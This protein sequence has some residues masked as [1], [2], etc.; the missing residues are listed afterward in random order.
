MKLLKLAFAGWILAC[1][2]TV[3]I[4]NI[5]S[6]NGY[7]VCRSLPGYAQEECQSAAK[8]EADEN[9]APTLAIVWLISIVIIKS[10]NKENG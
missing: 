10:Y 3:V 2:P 1:I 8:K 7:R 6:S 4:W 5:I 9:F